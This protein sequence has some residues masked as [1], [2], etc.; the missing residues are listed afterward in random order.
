MMLRE[1]K[2]VELKDNPFQMIGK[3]WL[4]VT[5]ES[6]GKVNAMTASWGFMGVMWGK[7][8]VSIVLRPQR[9]TKELIDA[10]STFSIAV[11]DADR[12]STYNYLGSVSG[13]DEDKIPKTGLTVLH[14]GET[15]YFA[16][17]KTVF[18]CRKLYAQPYT[19][20]AFIDPGC[21]EKWYPDKDYH[22]MYIA[23]IEKVL[24]NEG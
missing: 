20:N 11:L 12:R 5:A 18:I 14:D 17:A 1:I 16:E 19:P 2:P 10:S 4:L 21:D 9:Y 15:P 8:V 24:V 3:D 13:H 23:E 22:T 7:D 6:G